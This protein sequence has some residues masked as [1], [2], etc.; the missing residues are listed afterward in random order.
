MTPFQTVRFQKVFI[1]NESDFKKN[2]FAAGNSTKDDDFSVSTLLEKAN[3]NVG[4][5]IFAATN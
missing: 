5:C 4:T 3:R 2:C 1:L